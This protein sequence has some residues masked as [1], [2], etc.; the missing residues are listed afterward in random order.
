MAA[1]RTHALQVPKNVLINVAGI[2]GQYNARGDF[3]IATTPALP[4]D[5]SPS[6]APLIF[7]HIVTGGDYTSEFL[8]VSPGNNVTGSVEF[9]SKSGT[10]MV[11]PIQQ[12]L[13]A[14]AL[15]TGV[16]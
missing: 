6:A 9:I 7:P 16:R 2:R 10:P 14:I 4:E 13:R 15:S 3:L 5:L 8:L 12:Q 11:L 1:A